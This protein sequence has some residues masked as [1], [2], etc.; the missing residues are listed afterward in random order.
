MLWFG[1]VYFKVENY[2]YY[3]TT[4]VELYWFIMGISWA[5]YCGNC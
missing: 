2:I 1:G 4:Y 3:G 5:I